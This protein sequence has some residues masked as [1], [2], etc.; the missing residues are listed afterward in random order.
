ML[1]PVE[2]R[3]GTAEIGS[4]AY[5]GAAPNKKRIARNVTAIFLVCIRACS[6]IILHE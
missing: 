4:A 2:T 5:A 1:K 3:I 6:Y